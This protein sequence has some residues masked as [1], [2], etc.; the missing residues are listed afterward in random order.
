LTGGTLTAAESNAL[1][2]EIMDGA[3][4]ATVHEALLKLAAAHR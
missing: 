4:A 2:E 3:D 1:A